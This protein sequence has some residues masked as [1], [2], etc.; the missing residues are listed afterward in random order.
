[1]TTDIQPP[2]IVVAARAA[3]PAQYPGMVYALD[4]RADATRPVEIVMVRAPGGAY[5][6][7]GARPVRAA[8]A[9]GAS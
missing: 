8:R 5:V 3:I 4:P 2:A 1:M 9:G 6:Q 7:T